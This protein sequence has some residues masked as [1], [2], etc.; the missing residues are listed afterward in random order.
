MRL[1]SK[2]KFEPFTT[3]EKSFMLFPDGQMATGTGED[4]FHFLKLTNDKKQII[5]RAHKSEIKALIFD[6]VREIYPEQGKK[7][8]GWQH[9]FFETIEKAINEYEEQ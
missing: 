9:L 4:D 1:T 5:L 3:E 8:K 2:S 6:L 7:F